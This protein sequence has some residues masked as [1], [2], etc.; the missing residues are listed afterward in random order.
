MLDRYIELADKPAVP[1][2]PVNGR[3]LIALGI[4]PG[5]GMGRLLALLK[6]EFLEKRL[7][8]RDELLEFAI[9]QKK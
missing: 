7:T 4:P 1:P 8:T 9:R 2:L 3:D 6:D 5:T